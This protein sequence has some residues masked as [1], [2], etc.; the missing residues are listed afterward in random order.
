MALKKTA[1]VCEHLTLFTT[2]YTQFVFLSS[3][4]QKKATINCPNLWW[5]LK[6]QNIWILSM[7]EDFNFK[8]EKGGWVGGK[9]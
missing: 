6:L 8:L 2:Y 7:Q 5:K 3:I 9:Q 1:P 4:I